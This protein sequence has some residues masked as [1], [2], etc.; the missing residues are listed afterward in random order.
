[1][2]ICRLSLEPLTKILQSQNILPSNLSEQLLHTTVVTTTAKKSNTT[3][4]DKIN[5]ENAVSWQRAVVEINLT[6]QRVIADGR[7]I[8]VRRRGWIGDDDIRD[9]VEPW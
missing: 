1:M 4:A 9:D 8:P 2:S 5:I 7:E 6:V 3:S